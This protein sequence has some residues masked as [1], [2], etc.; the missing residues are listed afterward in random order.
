MHLTCTA[1]VQSLN[2]SDDGRVEKQRSRQ[3]HESP[4]LHD[5]LPTGHHLLGVSFTINL[6]PNLCTAI[7][8]RTLLDII[9]VSYPHKTRLHISPI[10]NWNITG[11]KQR[12]VGFPQPTPLYQGQLQTPQS[13]SVLCTD[14]CILNRQSP[15]SY[16]QYIS[17]TVGKPYLETAARV[18]HTISTEL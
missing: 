9:V 10:F 17:V 14:V 7:P 15:R 1:W 2:T 18:Q 13:L 6:K 8:H 4:S 12:M 11:Q 3:K 5:L 16:S